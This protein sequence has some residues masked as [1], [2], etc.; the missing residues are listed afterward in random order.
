MRERSSGVCSLIW[1]PSPSCRRALPRRSQSTTIP[2]A[3]AATTSRPQDGSTV[4]RKRSTGGSL[5][6]PNQA[7]ADTPATGASGDAGGLRGS[8][9]VEHRPGQRR[10]LRQVLRPRGVGRE[11]QDGALH[12]DRDVV[13]GGRDVRAL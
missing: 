7:A 1:V 12:G 11:G 10:P 2:A 6:F 4:K 5:G 3:P 9:L 13:A 8:V